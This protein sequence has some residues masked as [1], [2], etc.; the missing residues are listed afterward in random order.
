[1][2]LA[3]FL[4][5][6][7][8]RLINAAPATKPAEAAAF[9]HHFPWRFTTI[10]AKLAVM[11]IHLSDT[12]G[13]VP[14]G[15][16]GRVRPTANARR[17]GWLAALV[18]W[19]CA[20]HNPMAGAQM[21]AA[22]ADP[23]PANAWL[24][25]PDFRPTADR[26]VGWR[27][28]WT[29]RFPGATPP[30][31]WSRRVKGLTTTI[32]YQADKPAGE[33]G[34][35][36]H[37]LEY[38]TL[39]EWLV[40]G[41]FDVE[42]P[43]RDI[44]RDFLGGEDTI[45]PALGAKAGAAVWTHLRVGTETQSRH[46]HNEG[47]CGDLNVDFVHVFGNLP[48][49]GAP[50][51]LAVP[52]D[53]K[54]AYAHTYFHSPAAGEVGLRV[55]YAAA[56][57]K[58]FLN[59]QPVAIK[60][61]EAVKVTIAPGWNRLL[62]KAAS[63][64]ATAPEGQNSWVSRW[65][66]AAYLEPRLPVAYE[67]RN[68]AWMTKMTGRSMSQPIVVGD[69]LFVGS[70]MTDLLCLDKRTGKILWLRSNTPY[71]ALTEPERATNAPV[72]E[73][74]E[75]LVAKLNALND[76]A[77]A[78]INAAVSPTGLSSDQQAELDKLLKSKADAERAVHDAF[79]ALNRKKYPQMYKNEVSS[80]NPA[81]L[82]DGQRVYWIC[83][84]GMKGPGAHVISC[85]DLDGRRVWSRHD[86]GTFGSL[87][88]GNHASLN[89]IDGKVICAANMTL[90]AFDAQTGKELW[91]NSPDDWQ[92]GGH[93]SFSPIAVRV[94]D[95]SAILSNRYLHR[96]SDGTVICPTRLDVW[97]V[98]TPIVENGVMYNPCRWHGFTAPVSFIG[99]K[100]PAT[101]GPGAKAEIVFELDG[102]DATMPTRQDGPL[103]MV[104]SPLYVD[105]I[106]YSV[107][108][109]GGL[110]AVDTFAKKAHYRRY[111]D[112]YNRYNRYVYGVAA[113]PTLAGKHIFITDNAGYTHILE[114]GP[115]F[116]ELACNV[117]ENIHLSG[118]GG[119]PCRQE[120]FYTSAYFDGQAMY[121]RGEEY[122]YCIGQN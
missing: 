78:A 112:G 106:V 96:A 58:V 54:V 50:K 51:T 25:S 109:G 122:L 19:V 101:A 11:A 38:F 59:G 82:S 98:L 92:N 104:A 27:G 46:Y 74:I 35:G 80:S 121:L 6:F 68:L 114:P 108:M 16:Q 48:E 61:G 23:K 113:S 83:G 88:H 29:G 94:G 12:S 8:V 102:K 44:E 30:I 115:Q 13:L 79:A 4:F 43:V 39:K 40:A 116:K 18:L 9:E 49:S 22:E 15:N 70:A 2:F 110:A 120:S 10:L 97:G 118:Q 1:M 66:F 85:F 64:A 91:R 41:P 65:R 103:F 5:S 21:A 117:L 47:T 89:L 72:R 95:T 60:R 90:A 52:L 56:A 99:V 36:S 81:P 33:P 26:P 119:N 73:P 14:S 84:G 24:G 57:I 100:V 32:K 45:Q 67:T 107:E 86:D 63:A 77:V 34:T 7:S 17:R 28:D 55:N 3:V 76:A 93:G 69:R 111:L 105:G 87:E 20:C 53:K 75:P 37:A 42:D 71:D 31:D 62:V